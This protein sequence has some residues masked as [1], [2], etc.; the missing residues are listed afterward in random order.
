MAEKPSSMI[1]LGTIAPD[2]KLTDAVTNKEMSLEELKSSIATIVM[3]ICNHCPYVV[4]INDGLV[5][6]S[7]KYIDKGMSFIAISSN[8]I[9][10]Y[11]EDSPAKMKEYALR[12]GYPF[13]YLFDETQNVARVYQAQCTPEFYVFDKSMKLVYR[14]QFDN[15]R[16][17]N[18]VPVTGKDLANALDSIISGKPMKENQIPSIGCSIKWKR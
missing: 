14:G 10:N 15:S 7:N 11:P 12:L 9:V 4:H 1:P 18:G 13:P 6:L 2:F 3:F 16:P 8:D 5:L 17:G